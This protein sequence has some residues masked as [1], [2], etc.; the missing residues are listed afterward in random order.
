MIRP[1]NIN[2][3]FLLILFFSSCGFKPIYQSTEN[4]LGSEIFAIE[5]L[6][7]PGYLIKS[8]IL[9]EYDYSS[10][11]NQYTIHLGTNQQS[12]PLITNTDGTVSKYRIEVIMTFNVT[13]PNSENTIYTDISRGFAEYLVQTSEIETDEKLKQ[14]IEIATNEALQMMSIKIQS[15]ILQSQ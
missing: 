4:S 13:Q 9:E 5:F 6:N 7:D 11:Q 2:I 1:I 15:N 12:V 8:K 14:A 10:S 3:L